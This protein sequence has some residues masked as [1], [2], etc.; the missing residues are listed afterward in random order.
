MEQKE[1]VR[2]PPFLP[3]GKPRLKI[4]DFEVKAG[5]AVISSAVKLLE[6]R[7]FNGVL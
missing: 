1:N 5:I 2:P 4:R 6:N 7:V 3:A